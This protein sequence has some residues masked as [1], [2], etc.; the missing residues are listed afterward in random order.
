MA[1]EVRN[2]RERSRYELVLDGEVVGIAD[3]RVRDDAVVFPHTEIVP[4]RR[5]QGLGEILVRGALDDVRG[6]GLPVIPACWFVAEFI[7]GHEDY[8]D[9]LVAVRAAR[10]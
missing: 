9:L 6:T 5:G 7:D 1:T 3:Y 10:S 4:A 2:N 8:Q